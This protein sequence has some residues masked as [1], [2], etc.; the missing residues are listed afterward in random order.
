MKKGIITKNLVILLV[1]YSL[2]V[3]T[4]TAEAFQL[5]IHPSIEGLYYTE[6]S[7]VTVKELQWGYGISTTFK[8]R[9]LYIDYSYYWCTSKYKGYTFYRRK[10]S[11]YHDA[12]LWTVD[13][14]IKLIPYTYLNISHRNWSVLID[15]ETYKLTF[16]GMEVKYKIPCNIKTLKIYPFIGVSYS[17]KKTSYITC[18]SGSCRLGDCYKYHTGL[19]VTYKPEN[20]QNYY[21][22]TIQYNHIHISRSQL[23]NNGIY[24]PNSNTEELTIKFGVLTNFNINSL[25]N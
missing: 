9:Q 7:I 17:P 22:L 12:H 2:L 15:H 14:K 24:E 8:S 16:A 10:I 3:I 25:L 1:I 19:E 6:Y 11:F 20:S 13:V 18:N 21:F 4:T 23:N 5:S